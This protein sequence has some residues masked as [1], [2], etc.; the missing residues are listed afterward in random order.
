MNVASL[1]LCKALYEVNGWDDTYFVWREDLP[2]AVSRVDWDEYDYPAYDL[3]YLL[4]KLPVGIHIRRKMD[5]YQAWL[6]PKAGEMS[7]FAIAPEDAA[8]R[9][10]VELF[11]QN[12]LTRKSN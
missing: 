12:I 11:K 7:Y 1:S 9:L 5:V 4:R 8:C 2:E 3:G 6:L 10:A